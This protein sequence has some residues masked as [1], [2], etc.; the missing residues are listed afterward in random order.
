MKNKFFQNDVIFFQYLKKI[1]EKCSQHHDNFST[2]KISD[3]KK[4]ERTNGPK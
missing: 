4:I 1:K 2:V 3:K